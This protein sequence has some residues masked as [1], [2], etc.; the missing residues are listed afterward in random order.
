[1]GG[2]LAASQ[3]IAEFRFDLRGKPALLSSNKVQGFSVYDAV[4]K[5]GV[6][7]HLS[8]SRSCRV[9]GPSLSSLLS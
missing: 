1:M 5:I 2:H 7:A 3:A 8:V 4:F 9:R 6:H